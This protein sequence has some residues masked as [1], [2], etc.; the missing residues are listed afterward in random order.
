MNCPI[1]QDK[2]NDSRVLP[3]IHSFCLKCLQQHCRNKLPGD[4]VPCPVCRHEFQ[5]PKNGVAGLTAKTHDKEAEPSTVCEVCSSEQSGIPATVYC[6][7]C[8][9]KL[10]ERCSLPHQKWRGGP[11]DVR[12]LDTLSP[13]HQSGGNYCDKHKERVKIYCLDCQTSVC[14]MCFIESHKTHKF[15]QID[16]MMEEFGRS[17]D[18]EVKPV[19][20]HISS[21]RG[22]AAQVETESSKLF[23]SLQAMEQGIRNKGEEMKQS[24]PYLID[25]EVGDLI[26]KL[27]SVKSTAEEEVKSQADAVQLALT[28]MEIFRTASLELKSKVSP[29]D[30]KQAASDVR[31]RANILLQKHT[32]P[33]EY[34]APSYT[35]TPVNIDEFLRVDR[36]FI[37]HVAK[38][39]DPGNVYSY[40]RSV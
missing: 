7:D 19:T 13:E 24:L 34:H 40:G 36:N 9:Q 38:V 2:L 28:E 39:E 27:R 35:F 32:I 3:C 1:C 11:H 29:G 25:L 23:S 4:E 20:K 17:I 6:V 31:D 18:R 10:C 22:A 14:S 26:H 15:E 12:T 30:I 16:N 33:G 8:H 37:G 5:I 21:F